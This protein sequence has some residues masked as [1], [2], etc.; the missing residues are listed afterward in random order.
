MLFR[1]LVIPIA[2]ALLTGCGFAQ[3]SRALPN[4]PSLSAADV[5][6]RNLLYAS[7]S[8]DEP[9][10]VYA[11]PKGKLVGTLSGPIGPRGL[12]VDQSGDIFA[13]FVYIPG[14]VDEFAHA[15]GSPIA[16]LGFPVDWENACSVSPTTG[17]LAVVT[18]PEGLQPVAVI[19][20]NRGAQGWGLERSYT[21]S[22]MNTLAYCGYDN[23]GNLFVDGLSASNTFV[24]AEL[25]KGAKQFVTVP[26]S[27]PM[28]GAGQVQWDGKHLAIGDMS[29]S[30]Y[31]IYQFAI[32]SSGATKVGSTQLNGS[33]NVQ[34]FWI[35]GGTIVAPDPSRSC[36]GSEKGCIGLYHYPAGGNAFTTIP[37]AG[38]LGATVSVAP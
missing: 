21:L 26:V 19:Y 34:Q 18:G 20:R 3:S 5:K 12:C 8:G 36:E 23:K 35:R 15:G 31:T 24:L 11:Y 25:A 37:L 27:Q 10:Y 7:T 33:A 1:I 22:F 2:V 28:A 29:G 9:L 6:G 14:G 17:A 30:P 4:V 16:Y 38:A 13:P 32:N